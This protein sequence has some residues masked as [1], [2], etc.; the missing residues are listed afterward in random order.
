MLSFYDSLSNSL[1][2]KLPPLLSVAT[3][4]VVV[5]GDF[6]LLT[7]MSLSSIMSVTSYDSFEFSFIFGVSGG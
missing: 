2:L 4:A 7:K 5:A 6:Y 1:I 3:A